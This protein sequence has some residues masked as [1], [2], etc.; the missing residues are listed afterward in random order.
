M[1][2]QVYTTKLLYSDGELT[3]LQKQAKRVVSQSVRPKTPPCM[4]FE[5]IF[6]AGYADRSLVKRKAGLDGL[7]F[8]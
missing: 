4:L 6:S 8:L 1:T 2:S 5:N 3:L 7:E